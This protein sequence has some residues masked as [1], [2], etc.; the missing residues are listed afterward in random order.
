MFILKSKIEACGSPVL[1]TLDTFP[2]SLPSSRV[3]AGWPLGERGSTSDG[4]Q[5]L[6]FALMC[7][8][9]CCCCMLGKGVGLNR[10]LGYYYSVMDPGSV[11]WSGSPGE[12][13]K[14]MYVLIQMFVH[15]VSL[16]F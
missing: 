13:G 9:V 4:C 15:A 6:Y 11:W 8:E 1:H 16:L 3:A 10:V 7:N 12:W 14:F 2:V 5:L